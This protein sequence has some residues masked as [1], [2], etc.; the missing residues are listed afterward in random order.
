M[1]IGK[2]RT[3]DDLWRL[4]KDQ[5]WRFKRPQEILQWEEF[6]SQIPK[7]VIWR[8]TH[9]TTEIRETGPK[10]LCHV[11]RAWQK[12]SMHLGHGSWLSHMRLRHVPGAPCI[13]NVWGAKVF[14]CFFQ[15]KTRI[16]IT[17]PVRISHYKYQP[18]SFRISRS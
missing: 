10:K 17:N 3:S 8:Q 7:Q 5:E 6:C 18:F 13:Q 12:Q 1:Q 11:P 14:S 9:K 16:F 2:S 15:G 4:Q